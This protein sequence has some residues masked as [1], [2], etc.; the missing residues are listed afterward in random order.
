MRGRVTLNH[1]ERAKAQYLADCIAAA[2]KPE[3][4]S[5]NKNIADL[6]IELW[7]R[8]TGREEP[9]GPSESPRQTTWD[10]PSG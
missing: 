9:W 7:C 3:L 1:K 6:R 10:S 2:L 8:A 5:I 4:D